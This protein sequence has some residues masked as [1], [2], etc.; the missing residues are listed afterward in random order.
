MDMDNILTEYR[1]KVCVRRGEL[2]LQW[3][4]TEVWRKQLV[5]KQAA[6]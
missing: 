3:V 6:S 2:H 5:Y 4:K 1:N